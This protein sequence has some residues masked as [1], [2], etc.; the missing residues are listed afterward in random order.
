MEPYS[1]RDVVAATGA[2]ESDIANWRIDGFLRTEFDPYGFSLENVMEIGLLKECDRQG[3][4]LRSVSKDSCR[5][6]AA[7]AAGQITVGIP[8]FGQGLLQQIREK[9]VKRLYGPL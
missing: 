5:A 1:V 3:L 2:T 4:P 7:M 8:P 6:A 9:I